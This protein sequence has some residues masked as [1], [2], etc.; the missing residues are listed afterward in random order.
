[1]KMTFE[2][3]IINWQQSFRLIDLETLKSPAESWDLF[4]LRTLIASQL[5]AARNT[6]K[7]SW[8]TNI[9]NTF[10]LV[11]ILIIK[12]TIKYIIN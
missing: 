11:I 3:W 7:K 1:M 4:D 2:Q 9:Q 5:K 6:L 12:M 10:L 8:F